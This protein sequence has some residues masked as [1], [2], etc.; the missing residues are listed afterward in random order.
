MRFAGSKSMDL[1]GFLIRSNALNIQLSRNLFAQSH[2]N[3][4][5]EYIN[6]WQSFRVLFKY[7]KKKLALQWYEIKI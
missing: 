3:F 4:F 5:R 7:W 6:K 1:N 2:G